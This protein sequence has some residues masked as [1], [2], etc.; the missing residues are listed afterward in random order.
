MWNILCK[1]DAP[2]NHVEELCLDLFEHV[3]L[4][5]SRIVRLKEIRLY[6]K[7]LGMNH[8]CNSTVLLKT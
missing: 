7:L 3:M 5:E 6:K 1:G 8:V 4:C 2:R